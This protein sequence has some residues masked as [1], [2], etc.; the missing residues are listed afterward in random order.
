MKAILFSDRAPAAIGP[1]SQGVE[2]NGICYFS[3]QIPLNQETGELVSGDFEKEV[4]QVFQ[5]MKYL[6]EDNNLSF[7]DVFK[8]TI[9][10]S[11]MSLFAKLNEIYGQY[12]KE[13]YP[14]R[15]CVAVKTLPKSVN[16][17]IE[18]IA[19]RG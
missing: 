18:M 19:A 4:H 13:P 12:F 2:V 11:D 1:Y 8:T 5:N 14:A 16:V 3:G 10:I 15:S 6:L 9:F 7:A 17:E